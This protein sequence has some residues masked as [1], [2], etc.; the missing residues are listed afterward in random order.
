MSIGTIDTLR[1]RVT[2]AYPDHRIDVLKSG[3]KWQVTVSLHFDSGTTLT[4]FARSELLQS[5]L[6]RAHELLQE[7]G[8]AV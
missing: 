8:H 3:R 4:V 7:A 6:E 1:A 5:A 2:A